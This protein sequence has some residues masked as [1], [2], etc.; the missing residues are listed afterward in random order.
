M[1]EEE[2]PFEKVSDNELTELSC[3]LMCYKAIFK[4]NGEQKDYAF[5]LQ[6]EKFEALINRESYL[7]KLT[8]K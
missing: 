6:T 5:K 7:R 3:I 1:S 2:R 4:L 8:S